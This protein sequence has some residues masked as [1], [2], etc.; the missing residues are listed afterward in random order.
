MKDTIKVTI[1]AIIDTFGMLLILFN[2][3]LKLRGID[4]MSTIFQYDI[5][6]IALEQMIRCHTLWLPNFVR[7]NLSTDTIKVLLISGDIR[8]CVNDTHTKVIFLDIY[9]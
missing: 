3:I 4:M 8:K 6:K 5:K 1:K 9:H 2:E 7:Q